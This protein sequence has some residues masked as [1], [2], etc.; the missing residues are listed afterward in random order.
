MSSKKLEASCTADENA[1]GAVT[2]ENSLADSQKAEPR[3]IRGPSN[4]SPRHRP[5]RAESM[6][7]QKPV[8]VCSQQHYLRE[9]KGENNPNAHQWGNGQT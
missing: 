6:F 3:V 1:N 4:S 8:H 2:L 7:T 5:K 9:P